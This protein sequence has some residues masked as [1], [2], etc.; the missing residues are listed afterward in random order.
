LGSSRKKRKGGSKY[1][2]SKRE[3]WWL[4]QNAL[5][6]AKKVGPR[7]NEKQKRR[8][9]KDMSQ[10]KK[11]GNKKKARSLKKPDNPGKALL[12]K[13][14]GLQRGGRSN[15]N[16][17]SL[18]TDRGQTPWTEAYI[19]EMKHYRRNSKKRTGEKGWTACR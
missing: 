17:H 18:L 13:E 11:R 5:K 15:N 2:G 14:E 9:G 7:S 3:A 1:G 8:R 4:P 6:V 19:G 16:S 12:L 10:E